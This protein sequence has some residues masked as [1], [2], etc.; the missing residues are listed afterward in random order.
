CEVMTCHWRQA[1]TNTDGR[2]GLAWDVALSVPLVVLMR[3]QH[4]HARAME[5][6][7]AEH[8]VARVCRGRQDDPRP[9]MRAHATIARAA[10]ALGKAG[11]E[12]VHALILHVAKDDGCADVQRLSSDTT[13]QAWPIGSP[14]APA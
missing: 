6:S 8:G 14:N 11:V 13:A 10:T 7:G 4:L 5:A 3:G 1:G 9:P 12:E 2:P